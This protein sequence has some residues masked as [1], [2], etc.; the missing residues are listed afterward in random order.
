MSKQIILCVTEGGF[1]QKKINEV[2]FID[3][4]LRPKYLSEENI[5][6]LCYGTN[7]YEL[8][9]ELQTDEFLDTYSIIQKNIKDKNKQPPIYDRDDIAEIYLFFD[10]DNHATQKN[11]ISS[12]VDSILEM[13]RLFDNETDNGKLYISYPMFEAYKHPIQTQRTSHLST[14]GSYKTTVAGICD[15]KLEQL[16]KLSIKQWN[17]YLLIHFRHINKFLHDSDSL[18]EQYL[19]EDFTQSFIYQKQLK[20]YIE[21][22]ET[23]YVVSPFVLFLL[24]YLGNNLLTKLKLE[25]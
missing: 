5:E 21:P 13:L 12:D 3:K 7:I 18:P 10:L 9:R 24:D 23:I 15:K 2:S 19:V 16:N 22:N 14:G 17:E 8:F 25:I 20:D 11:L 6:F 1:K 4:H